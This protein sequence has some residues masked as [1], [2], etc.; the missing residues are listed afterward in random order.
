MH[1]RAA[2][3]DRE[4][5]K[6][7]IGISES[8]H[9]LMLAEKI[10]SH[11]PEEFPLPSRFIPKF[12]M[13]IMGPFI[14]LSWKFVGRNIGIPIAFDTSLTVRDLEIKFRPLSESVHDMVK[15]IKKRNWID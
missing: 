3:S 14:G 5:G 15:Q 2:L 4:S 13:Y 10:E 1:I 8:G 12:L 6:R 7:Y 9:I 11:F